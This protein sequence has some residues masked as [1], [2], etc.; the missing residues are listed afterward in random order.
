MLIL[1]RR[2]WE[3]IVIGD[4]IVITVIECRHGRAR[5]GITA[6]DM[7]PIHRREVYETI[8]EKEGANR[9]TIPPE[10]KAEP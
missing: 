3:D 8:K 1:W 9:R 6:P 2:D 4:D 10:K 7:V 5:I